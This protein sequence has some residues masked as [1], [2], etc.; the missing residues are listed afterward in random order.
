[1]SVPDFK[2]SCKTVLESF[3]KADKRAHSLANLKKGSAS[4]S[5]LSLKKE[6]WLPCC[7]PGV[8]C[9]SRIVSSIEPNST[10]KGKKLLI[11]ACSEFKY[12]LHTSKQNIKGEIK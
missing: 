9:D 2:Q 10:D 8:P 11:V 6:T 3:S 12:C 7:Y 5:K 4:Y 1:M